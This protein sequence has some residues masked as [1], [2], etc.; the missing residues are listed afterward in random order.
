MGLA[1][2][3]SAARV[4]AA[5]LVYTLLKCAAAA[6]WGVNSTCRQDPRARSDFCGAALVCCRLHEGA[7]LAACADELCAQ[8]YHTPHPTSKVLV[9][10]KRGR[11]GAC[12]R[13]GTIGAGALHADSRHCQPEAPHTDAEL[14]VW[15]KKASSGLTAAARSACKQT[16]AAAARAGFFACDAAVRV[17]RPESMEALLSLVAAFPRVKG[18]GVGHSWWQQQFCA[19][20]TSDAINIVLTE[21]PATRLA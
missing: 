20:N 11:A 9:L 19:G 17:G 2:A 14:P 6:A 5:I 7:T 10:G 1:R 18:V 8:A 21:M 4:P 12:K 16:C 13:G 15:F 3:R